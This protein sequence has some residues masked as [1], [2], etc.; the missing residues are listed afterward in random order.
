MSSYPFKQGLLYIAEN[1]ATIITSYW[2]IHLGTFVVCTL[3][4][5]YSSQEAISEEVPQL[6][7]Y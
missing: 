2:Q 5:I 4:F 1:I 7:L 3:L 6:P